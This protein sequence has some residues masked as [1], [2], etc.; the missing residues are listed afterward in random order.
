LSRIGQ[1]SLSSVLQFMGSR[2]AHN[3][4]AGYAMMNISRCSLYSGELDEAIDTIG[5]ALELI[6]DA[7]VIAVYLETQLQHASV[8][9]A[10]GQLDD[11]GTLCENTRQEI[12]EHGINLM[13]A[14]VD[15]VLAKI[16][17]KIGDT[18]AALK[19]INIVSS[20]PIDRI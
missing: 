10:Q 7:G 3:A 12:K 19:E 18:Q 5:K 8:L 6:K 14:K 11:T 16:F 15:R 4:L 2:Y 13:G 20:W 9:L 17:H 1:S